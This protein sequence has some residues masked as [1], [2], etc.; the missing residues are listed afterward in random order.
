M[1]GCDVGAHQTSLDI[2]A[3]QSMESGEDLP[4]PPAQPL[5][6]STFLPR[7]QHE[8]D[9]QG[10]S[11]HQDLT[12]AT[13]TYDLVIP[14]PVATHPASIAGGGYS[15]L[16]GLVITGIHYH[17]RG[18]SGDGFVLKVQDPQIDTS[19][20]AF[21]VTLFSATVDAVSTVYNSINCFIPLSR[22]GLPLATPSAGIQN[23]A[24]LRVDLTQATSGY[25]VVEGIHTT[26]SYGA[27]AA[28]G[29]PQVFS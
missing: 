14:K 19:T 27:H 8:Q 26:N 12:D 15:E 13:S 2:G 20:P 29:S 5:Y 18:E 7:P 3:H 21:E 22:A 6:T 23:G 1:A 17:F 11:V 4:P 10:W 16:C 25:L 9:G 24:K 28:T